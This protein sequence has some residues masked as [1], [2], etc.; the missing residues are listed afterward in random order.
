MEEIKIKIDGTERTIKMEEPTFGQQN[1]ML[2]KVFVDGKMK[3]EILGN[4]LLLLACIKEAPFD[5]TLEGIRALPSKIG[6]KLLNKAREL[7]TYDE[8]LK[9]NLE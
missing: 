3:D 2:R 5:L 1:E 7:V 4:E 6:N 8:D 9:K